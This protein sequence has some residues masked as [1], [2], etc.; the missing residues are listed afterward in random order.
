MSALVGRRYA[1]ALYEIAKAQNTVADFAKDCKFIADTLNSSKE[2]LRAVQSPV[3]NQEKK[4]ALLKAIFSGR[5]GKALEDAL[6]LLVQKG[7]AAFIPS[8]MKEFQA[9]LNEAS[10]VLVAQVE[11]AIE[12]SEAERQ[13]I[14]QKLEALSGKKVQLESKV[15]PS[16]IGG[17]TARV[18]DTVIDGSV[19]HQLERLRE[20]LRRVSFN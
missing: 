19:K 2:L 6:M 5:V 9:L 20:H 16:L 14:A 10:G 8:V 4:Q 17:F 12:L 7:R 13:A 18:G 3:I 15:N 1:L 11:S